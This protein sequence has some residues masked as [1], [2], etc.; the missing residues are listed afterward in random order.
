MAISSLG[1]GSGLDLNQL[2][3]QLVAAEREPKEQRLN[4]REERIDAQISAF[5][6]LTSSV[7]QVGSVLGDLSGFEPTQSASVADDSVANVTVTGDAENSDFSLEVNQLAQS[8][9]VA[10]AAGDFDS[11]DDEVGAGQLQIQVGN[12]NAVTIDVEEGATL[13]DVRNAINDSEAGVT[14]SIVNDG[15]GARLVL[16]ANETGADNTISVTATEDPEGSG[17]G[18]L[19]SSNLTET[20]A[21][22]DAEAV[23]NGLTVTSSSNTLS[24]TIEGLEIELTG[25]SS[26][27][28]TV[29][30]SEDRDELES[31]LQSFVENYNALIGQTNQLTAYDPEEDEAAVLTGD[32]TVRGI[33][34]RLGNAL[35][36]P[37]E[38]AGGSNQTLA[39]LGIISNRD[40]TLSF[41]STRFSEAMERDGFENISDTVRN[42]AGQM[43]D[44]TDSFTG[45]D[46]L[47]QVRQ[48]G[49]QS[50]LSRIERQR[51]DL[52]A[53]IERLEAN[54]VRQFSRMDSMVAQMQAT[55][56]QLM[57]QLA[58]TP[59]ARNQ[60]R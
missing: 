28:T 50:D 34:S 51:E 31:L 17:L 40:G 27:P 55:G 15:N 9:I 59:L 42:I 48:D 3:G 10:S 30:V 56:D 45:R 1:V 38:G 21:A 11:A 23:I 29:S 26:G 4:Q 5:G 60:S 41:D 49:L 52:E 47:I 20:R 54:W 12:G 19:D 24:D 57:A 36:Q 53:R 13:R 37:A 7:D 35:I 25:V 44:V 33:R 16:S 43:R 8:Q 14:A 46:G 6:E 32:S 22:Q 2:V 58:N 18:R 39:E